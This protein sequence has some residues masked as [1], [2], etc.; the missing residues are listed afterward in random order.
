MAMHLAAEGFLPTSG[1]VNAASG[2]HPSLGSTSSR[3]FQNKSDSPANQLFRLSLTLGTF[4]NGEVR[5]LLSDL[6]S[7][8]T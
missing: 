5:D 6:K 8:S 1:G 7:I 2:F 3:T 4:R